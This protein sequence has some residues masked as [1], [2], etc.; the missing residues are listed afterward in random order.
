MRV[1]GATELA[2]DVHRAWRW[3]CK[4]ATVVAAVR[5]PSCNER[6]SV[7][8]LFH[9]KLFY[10]DHLYDG[11]LLGSRL[12]FGGALTL[13]DGRCSDDPCSDGDDPVFGDVLI[14]YH[15]A[16]EVLGCM[17]RAEEVGVLESL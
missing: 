5:V 12:F 4:T 13:S 1:G 11:L 2:G 6:L 10:C 9:G 7:G 15:D 3:T 14:P 16:S 8:L 17:S